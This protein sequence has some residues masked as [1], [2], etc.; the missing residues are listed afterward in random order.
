MAAVDLS[1]LRFIITTFAPL[2]RNTRVA[3]YPTPALAPVMTYVLPA[4][5]PSRSGVQPFGPNFFLVVF[6][7][8]P[9]TS[10]SSH[11]V[12]QTKFHS[13]FSTAINCLL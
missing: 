1:V 12:E 2:D 9:F 5:E 10:R 3:S 7:Q 13:C 8:T 6:V 11:D 4:R